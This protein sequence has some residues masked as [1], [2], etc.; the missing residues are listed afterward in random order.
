MVKRA[1][2]ILASGSAL[3]AA[4]LLA[5]PAWNHSLAANPASAL[6]PY[7]AY[8]SVLS[9]SNSLSRGSERTRPLRTQSGATLPIPVNQV[10]QSGVLIVISKASQE[11]YVFRDGRLWDSSPVSTGKR[12]KATP[13]GI[14]P[15]L[16]KRRHHRSNLYSNAPM[17]YMQRMTWDGIAIHQGKLPGYP[18]SHGCIRLPGQFASAL[19]QLTARTTTTV[20]VTDHALETGA[21]ARL[22]AQH[23]PM[24]RAGQRG[25]LIQGAEPQ[26]AQLNVS[27]MDEQ[28]S[29]ASRD[30]TGQTAWSSL[31]QPGEAQRPGAKR[32]IANPSG[33]SQTIQLAAAGSMMEANAYWSQISNR[34]PELK[35]YKKQIVTATVNSKRYYRLRVSG[36][37][38]RA[39]CATMRQSGMDCFMVS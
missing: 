35:Q 10:L 30:K 18:A 34:F 2:T 31:A 26:L 14:F 36:K 4:T 22:L 29:L 8:N 37:G 13:S 9:E 15:I 20:V 7:I 24:P 28:L 27:A 1:F 33:R 38:A 21:Q 11:M 16:Q 3:G 12:G 25:H 39:S 5:V 23:M 32:A 17:P 19:F 6:P